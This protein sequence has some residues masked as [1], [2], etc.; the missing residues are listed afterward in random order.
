M[1]NFEVMKSEEEK[2]DHIDRLIEDAL[3]AEPSGR[4]PVDFTTKFMDR[5]Q[6]RIIWQEVISEFSVK[7]ALVLTSL[8][9]FGGIYYFVAVED[10]GRI[11]VFLTER[12]MAITSIAVVLAFTIFTDQVFLRYFLKKRQG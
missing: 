7:V 10:S 11:I 3:R 12:W 4:I 8:L 5:V 6:Q 1:C 2:S 9:V